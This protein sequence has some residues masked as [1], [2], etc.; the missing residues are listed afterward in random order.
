MLNEIFEI[1][2]LLGSLFKKQDGYKNVFDKLPGKNQ[3]FK[4]KWSSLFV[5]V[6]ISVPFLK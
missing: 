4:L 6:V 2:Y 1:N 3:N 5:E